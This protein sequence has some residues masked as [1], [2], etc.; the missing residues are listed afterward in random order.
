MVLT[1]F[2]GTGVGLGFG[3][4]CGFGIGWGFGGCHLSPT[5]SNPSGFC[6]RKNCGVAPT[7]I[8]WEVCH[9]VA[10]SG[11]DCFGTPLH[12]F[13][14]GIGGG[15]GVGFGLGWGFGN[16]FGTQY[17]TSK[18][19]FQGIEFD[20]KEAGSPKDSSVSS[21]SA[22]VVAEDGV[23]SP[24][25]TYSPP[26]L[27][28]LC[29]PTARGAGHRRIV[30]D[31][32]WEVGFNVEVVTP[33]RMRDIEAFARLV[34]TT[35]ALGGVHGAGMTNMVFLRKGA[36]LLQVVSWGLDWEAKGGRVLTMAL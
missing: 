18:I 25:Y 22:D 7:S 28:P 10:L 23:G 20:K 3:V 30:V 24:A 21:N 2:T 17:Q 12:T 9:K 14:L 27:P 19:T 35:S 4:G 11:C 29:T 16:A 5:F 8:H 31:M 26:H 36:V 6:L 1:S 33:E 34:A 15:C 32:A 13:G